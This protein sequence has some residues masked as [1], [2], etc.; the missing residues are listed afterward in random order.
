[1]QDTKKF[2]LSVCAPPSIALKKTNK[3]S[4]T[5]T[6]FLVSGIIDYNGQLKEGWLQPDKQSSD[7]YTTCN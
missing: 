3:K 4:V 2:S 1:M 5:T 7:P 6:V